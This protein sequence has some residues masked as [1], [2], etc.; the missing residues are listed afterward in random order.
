MPS[1]IQLRTLLDERIAYARSLGLA[2][3]EASEL[4]AMAAIA[5]RAAL[6]GALEQLTKIVDAREGAK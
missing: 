3:S 5:E 6:I 1:D 2:P 4:D